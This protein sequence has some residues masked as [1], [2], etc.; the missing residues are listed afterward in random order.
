MDKITETK[1]FYDLNSFFDDLPFFQFF[2]K[3]K[4][5]PIMKTDIEENDSH[6]LLSVEV[7]GLKKE[8]IEIYLENQYLVIKAGISKTPHEKLCKSL[9]KERFL[10]N[11]SRSFYVGEFDLNCIEAGLHDGVLYIS[12]PKSCNQKETKKLIEIK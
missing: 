8:D 9:R 6:Y 3:T 10:G 11:Y 5:H 4:A 7:P 1:N 2:D 12:I